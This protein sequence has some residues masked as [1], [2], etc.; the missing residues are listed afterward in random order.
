MAATGKYHWTTPDP[1][2][3]ASEPAELVGPDG[4][5]TGI[6]T[7]GAIDNFRVWDVQ[8]VLTS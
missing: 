5:L 3:P 1:K 2:G 7:T 8:A 6:T 4:T